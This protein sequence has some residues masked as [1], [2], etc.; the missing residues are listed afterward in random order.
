VIRVKLCHCT[1]L[2]L[3]S[4]QGVATDQLVYSAIV[5]VFPFQLEY[6]GYS[7]V[8]GLVGWLLLSYVRDSLPSRLG[9]VA[10]F[11]HW[12]SAGL[13]ICTSTFCQFADVIDVIG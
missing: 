1:E 3:H 4:T 13:V 9:G 11:F 6:L 10:D 12:Q 5:P 8:S 2:K 7:G